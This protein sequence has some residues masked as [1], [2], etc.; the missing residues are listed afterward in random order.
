MVVELEGAL[1]RGGQHQLGRAAGGGGRAGGV[2][3]RRLEDRTPLLLGDAPRRGPAAPLRAPVHRQLQPQDRAALH[4]HRL[5]PTADPGLT[6]MPMRCSSSSPA[7]Q[8]AEGGRR[9][10]RRRSRLHRRM[11]AAPSSASRRRREC[12]AAGAHRRQDQR[13]DRPALI[14]KL[15]RAGCSRRQHRPDRARRLHAAAG[16]PGRDRPHPRALGGRALPEHTRVLY[17][18]WGDGEDDEVLYRQ[19]RRLDGPQHVPPHRGGMG[20]A[21]RAAP[22][23]HRRCLVPYLH[24]R[25]DA[26]GADA[27]RLLP[28]ASASDGVRRS[29]R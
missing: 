12:R 23:R 11:R 9:R 24:D 8:D 1:R 7:R 25:Q 26:W 15:M 21:T 16:W 14:E 17:F 18:R 20:C 4:R 29:R 27:R 2:R 13:A 22:A 10:C 28:S 3:H 19:Q 6:A 5:S